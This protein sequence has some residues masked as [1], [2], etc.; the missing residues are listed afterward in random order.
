[1]AVTMW[2]Q[3]AIQATTPQEDPIQIGSLWI[4][5]SGTATLKV[6]T[7]VAPY[8]FSAITGG[9]GGG[10]WGT[11]TGTLA[12]QTDLQ[13]ALDAKVAATR[14]VV[15][16]NGLTGGGDLSADRTLAVGA[17]TGITVA[18][19]AVSV[20]QTVLKL[21]D[22]AAPDDNTDLNASTTAHGLAPK[23]TA[24]AAGLLSVL[25]IGNGETVRA[26]KP[27]FD[28]TNPAA[29]GAAGPGTALVAARRDHIHTLPALDAVAAPTD[30]TTLNASTSAHGLLPKL[31]NVV[32][33]FLNGQGGWT[34]PSATV[35][36]GTWTPVIGGA[37]G[38]SGQ[39]YS[40]QVGTYLKLGTFVMV[41]F[42]VALSA[43]GT[44]TGAAQISGLPFAA[45]NTANLQGICPLL[46]A[47]LATNWVNVIGHLLEN[48]SVLALKG[49]PAAGGDNT[50]GFSTTDIGNGTIF[51]GTFCYKAA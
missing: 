7:A 6:C 47:N 20:D 41:S 26:D 36:A 21:D 13:T 24:P 9:G 10:V 31:S 39:T 44:I 1:M 27:L 40:H 2:G 12:D 37:G 11:I 14:S 38:T 29:L 43:K 33:E 25:G 4:D 42:R 34:V 22:F 5:T 49:A 8:T 16:G 35:S 17:G 51:I 15:S 28:T 48:T 50:T 18:A 45:E 46:W 23:A 19:D 32:T 3:V 30:I